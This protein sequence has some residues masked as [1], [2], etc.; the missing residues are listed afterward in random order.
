MPPRLTYLSTI[1]GE[2]VPLRI[3]DPEYLPKNSQKVEVSG[4]FTVS[5]TVRVQYSDLS[6]YLQIHLNSLRGSLFMASKAIS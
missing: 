6:I 5:N 4:S 3:M 2:T 1:A